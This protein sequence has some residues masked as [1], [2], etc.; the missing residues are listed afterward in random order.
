MYKQF[1]EICRDMGFTHRIEAE[2]P[3]M[4]DVLFAVECGQ[5]LA[6]LPY[7]I[8]EYMHTDLVFCP[9]TAPVPSLRWG[10]PGA[11]SRGTRRY[12]GSLT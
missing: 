5:A 2:Y 3:A 9:W 4:E 6:I 11:D 8:R 7:H 1:R 12:I 10:W